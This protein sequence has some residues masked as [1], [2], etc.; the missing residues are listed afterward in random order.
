MAE[1]FPTGRPRVELHGTRQPPAPAQATPPASA[2]AAL[3][4]GLPAA[5]SPVRAAESPTPG[6]IAGGLWFIGW[7]IMAAVVVQAMA[8]GW[9]IYS[10]QNAAA[11]AA[12]IQEQSAA[13]IRQ[14]QAMGND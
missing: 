11:A 8:L 9:A 3:A 5:S 10:A 2:P 7:A 12:Q 13:A 6:S 14:I 1:R 4:Y